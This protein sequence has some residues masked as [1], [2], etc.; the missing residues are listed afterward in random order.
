LISH[1]NQRLLF[2]TTTD[3]S[4]HNVTNGGERVVISKIMLKK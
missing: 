4:G 2:F 3:E 1:R